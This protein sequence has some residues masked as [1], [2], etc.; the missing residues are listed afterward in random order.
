MIQVELSFPDALLAF[1]LIVMLF[2]INVSVL[3]VRRQLKRLADYDPAEEERKSAERYRAAMDKPLPPETAQ[4]LRDR[5]SLSTKWKERAEQLHN[6]NRDDLAA[7]YAMC[8]EE[9]EELYVIKVRHPE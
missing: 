4:R 7:V 2:L 1:A 3:G 5:A 8:A 6:T 9:F